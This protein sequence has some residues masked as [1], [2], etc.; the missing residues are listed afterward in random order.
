MDTQNIEG[1]LS[2]ILESLALVVAL[3]S[4]WEHRTLS[5]QIGA[6]STNMSDTVLPSELKV[7][8][9]FAW[10]HGLKSSR[11]IRPLRTKASETKSTEAFES[12][13]VSDRFWLF[14]RPPPLCSSRMPVVA[15]D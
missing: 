6:V 3:L 2:I 15:V 12:I 8:T 14:P 5:S 13:I 1:L 9:G 4:W 7:V 11:A 10:L